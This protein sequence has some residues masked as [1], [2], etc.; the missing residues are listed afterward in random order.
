M[1]TFGKQSIPALGALVLCAVLGAVAAQAET[2]R[3]EAYPLDTCIVSGQKIGA[4]GE[5][6]IIRHNGREI[7]FC[8]SGCKPEFEAKP[9]EYLKKID[10]AIVAQQKPL[11]PLDT[12]V[13]SGK[14]L[15][16]G[17]VD[18]VYNNRLV[19]FC[20]PACIETLKKDPNKYLTKLD[21]AVV[22]K[23][24]PSYPLDRCVV[25]GKKLGPG[26]VDYVFG[27][28]LVRLY[29]KDSIQAFEKE[30]GKYLGKMDEATKAK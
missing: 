16:D 21:E 27:G 23:Q 3:S 12:C 18:Y 26:A 8:C 14:K 30:P 13:V 7:R 4:M 11:Y 10:A 22:A 25:S 6:A 24:K 9:D 5:P 19:R 2:V 17:A 29:S 1:R 20:C 15:G 28:R